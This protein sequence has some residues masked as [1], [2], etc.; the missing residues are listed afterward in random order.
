MPDWPL[1]GNGLISRVLM[2]LAKCIVG[3]RDTPGRSLGPRFAWRWPLVL[4]SDRWRSQYWYDEEY[5]AA[6]RLPPLSV[7]LA[8]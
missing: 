1:G 7:S 5:A 2:T 3:V 8:V 4:L 6:R